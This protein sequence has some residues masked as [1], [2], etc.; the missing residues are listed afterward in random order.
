M[1]RALL[2]AGLLGAACATTP[3]AAPAPDGDVRLQLGRLRLQLRPGAGAAPCKRLGG[4]VEA[5]PVLVGPTGVRFVSEAELA[6]WGEA[7]GGGA[8]IDEA[9]ALGYRGLE[10]SSSELSVTWLGTAE[11]PRLLGVIGRPEGADDFAAARLL[12]LPARIEELADE[13]GLHFLAAIPNHRTLLVLRDED[14]AARAL[15]ELV[16][17]E[18]ARLEPPLAAATFF[19]VTPDGIRAR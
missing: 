7:R 13:V 12:L 11:Q 15:A 19:Q 4:G 17:A 5:C 14:P 2:L 16:M 9:F 18:Q 8:M 6:A 3:D 10:L 1:K